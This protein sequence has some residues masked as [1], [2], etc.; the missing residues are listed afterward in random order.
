[1]NEMHELAKK[2]LGDGTVK[3][4]I[5][6][7]SPPGEGWPDEGPR[8][9]RPSF[10]TDPKDVEKL[11]FD[12]RCVHNLAAYLNP[13][14]PHLVKLGKAA[15]VVKGCDARAVA[16]LIREGQVKREDVVLIGVRCGG[17]A[18]EP[19][20][21]PSLTERDVADKCAGC[22]DR[23]PKLCDH[24]LGT[25]PPE[26]PQG[27][28]RTERLAALEKMTPAERWKFWSEALSH[29]VRCY[30]CREICPMCFCVT[31]IA[32]R[33]RPQWI[34]C[35]PTLRGNVAWH[36]TRAMHQAG[37]CVDCLECE[38]ACPEDIPLGLLNRHVAQVVERRFGYRASEDPTV[39][40][41]MGVY[42]SDDGEEFIA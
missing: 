38:R 5:G 2:L 8:G 9:V 34:D 27:T 21:G 23:E 28:R 12:S 4:V 42:R 1:M 24:L 13:R 20:L 14:R 41:P 30:A 15:V 29:C 17:V 7:E 33:N 19:S 22:P 36:M 31:C 32:D 26:P 16:G 25:L 3:V 37:R 10:V 40:M 35:S 18:R 6:Y 11:V 39:P